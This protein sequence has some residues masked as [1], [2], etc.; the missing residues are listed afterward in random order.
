M[1]PSRGHIKQIKEQLKHA[2]KGSQSISK[3]MQFIKTRADELANLGKPIDEE[4]L[5]EKILDGLDDDYKSLVD[6]IN[7]SVTPI[8]F[9]ELHEKLI[10]KE[11]SLSHSPSSS[12]PLPTSAYLT[13]SRSKP[14]RPSSPQNL[15]SPQRQAII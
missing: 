9:D 3:Y 12:I 8:S 14:W 13:K 5:I 6:F 10:D 15:Y 2:T 7:G 4:D 11:L 1:P